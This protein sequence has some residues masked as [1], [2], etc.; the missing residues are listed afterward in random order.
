MIRYR[1]RQSRKQLGPWWS[2][3]EEAEQHAIDL[4][5]ARRDAHYD[6]L[7]LADGIVIDCREEPAPVDE[8]GGP[9]G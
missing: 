4:D 9:Q 2:T 3:L 7:H 6:M 5:L 8:A 1:V